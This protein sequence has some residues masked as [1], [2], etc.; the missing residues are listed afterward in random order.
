V[1]EPDASEKVRLTLCIDNRAP[2]LGA[3]VDYTV[4]PPVISYSED[5]PDDAVKRIPLHSDK[6]RDDNCSANRAEAASRAYALAEV[7]EEVAPYNLD[8]TNWKLY[9]RYEIYPC[10]ADKIGKG[11]TRPIYSSSVSYRADVQQPEHDVAIDIPYGDITVVAVAYMVPAGND[12]DWF[13][14]TSALYSIICDMSRRQGLHN[15]NI[16]RDCFVACCEFHVSPTGIDDNVQHLTATLVRPQGRYVILADDYTSYLEIGG[17]ALDNTIARIYYP[18][19]V[20]TA[21]SVTAH[22]PTSSDFNFGYETDLALIDAGIPPYVRLGDDWS[23]VNEPRSN[24]NVDIS[25]SGRE[26]PDIISYN[27]GITVPLFS[28]RVTLV[29]GRWLTVKSEGSGG[30]IIDPDFADEIVIKF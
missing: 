14:D 20:N 1:E 11:I 4:Y 9:L 15:D 21:Y 23:F 19:Y 7:F 13:F 8:G 27:H 16:Y 24:I 5:L 6:D 10:T 22:V 18:S 12:G 25:V 3:V 26:I 29:V 17:M 30:V 2:Q 28:D